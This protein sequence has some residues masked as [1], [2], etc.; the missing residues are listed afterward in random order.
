MP[1]LII[2]EEMGVMS[3]SDDYDAEPM[4]TDMLEDIHD[5]IQSHLGVNSIDAS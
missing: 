5:S 4:S 1:P 2:E 3:S